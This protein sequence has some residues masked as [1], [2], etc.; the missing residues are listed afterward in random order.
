[1][2]YKKDAKGDISVT[3]DAWL[4]NFLASKDKFQVKTVRLSSAQ[5]DCDPAA[6]FAKTAGDVERQ[7]GHTI[8]ERKTLRCSFHSSRDNAAPVWLNSISG[9]GTGLSGEKKAGKGSQRMDIDPSYDYVNSRWTAA[10]NT[11]AESNN[12]TASSIPKEDSGGGAMPRTS[13]TRRSVGSN[14]LCSA[15]GVITD[16]LSVACLFLPSFRVVSL[17]RAMSTIRC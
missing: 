2:L 8:Q 5:A 16:A 11:P 4:S 6:L 1:M 9:A 15:F 12:I 14:Q 13:G 17:F 7:T 10:G 3:Q